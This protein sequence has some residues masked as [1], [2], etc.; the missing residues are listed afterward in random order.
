M[1][2]SLYLDICPPSFQATDI[3]EIPAARPLRPV[4][5]DAPAGAALPPWVDDLRSLPTV[6]VTLGTIF[7]GAPGV[8]EALLEGLGSEPLNVV[9]TVGDDRDPAEL[10]PQPDNVHVERYIPQSLLFPHCDAVVCHGG[11]GTTLAAFAHGLP[12][13]V[14]PQGA[15][16]FW[17]ADRCA[18]VGVGRRVLEGDLDPEVVRREVHAL[19]ERPGYRSKALQLKAE[20]DRMPSPEATVPLLESM[21]QGGAADG[22]RAGG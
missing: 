22:V 14:V 18:E 6:Y 8:F 1:F 16:Q 12:V 7:N 5:F 21:A 15:N 4:P 20:I 17:N 11:S 13:L 2:R 19:L 10:G 9:V 3:H